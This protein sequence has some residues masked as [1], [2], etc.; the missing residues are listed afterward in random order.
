MRVLVTGATGFVGP[1]VVSKFRARKDAVRIVTRDMVKATAELGPELDVVSLKDPPA[2]CLGGVDAVVNLMGEPIVGKRWTD[3]QRAELRRSRV[4]ATRALV[5]AMRGLPEGERPKV[6]VSASAVG[7]YGPCGDEELTEESAA[8][9]G[10][11]ED[12]CR[13]W[14]AAAREAESLGVRVVMIRIGIVLGKNGG[15]LEKMLPPFRLGLGGPIGNGAHWMSWIHK[16]D[17]ARLIVFAVDTPTLAGPVNGTAPSPV[18]N[19]TFT[20][21]L[22]KTLG[23]PAV[24]PV[25]PFALK[26]ALGDAAVLLTTGQ[27]VIPRKALRAGFAFNYANVEDALAQIL[28]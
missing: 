10:F 26:L 15:A 20:R 19:G 13:D 7:W 16:D 17:L 1:A 25:P 2:K 18:T 12:M 24:F 22:S 23:R 27:R 21:A 9:H 8:G 28:K 5:Q 3:A 14:E 4:D 6:L 11:L